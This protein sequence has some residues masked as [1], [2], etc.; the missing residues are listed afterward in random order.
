MIA[1]CYVR[2]KTSDRIEFDYIIPEGLK[3][4][5][6]DLVEVPFLNKKVPAVV[7]DIKPNSKF[8]KK[9]IIRPLSSNPIL[10]PEQ[11][12][13][14]Q[15]IAYEFL[16][17]PSQAL[18]SFLPNLNKKDLLRIHSP[19]KLK[20]PRS[21]K[22]F[23]IESN[24]SNRLQ[25]FVQKLDPTHQTLIIFSELEQIK[26]ALKTIKSLNP[27]F[28][29]L[30]WHSALTSEQK[31]KTWNKV[32]SGENCIILSS[33]H[34][35]FLPFRDLADI[36]LDKPCAFGYFEDQE[37]RYNAFKAAVIVSK[38]YRSNLYLADSSPN[39]EIYALIK[40][41]RVNL[42]SIKSSINITKLPSL[43]AI[44][45]STDFTKAFKSSRKVLVSGYFKDITRLLCEDCEKE[46]NCSNCRDVYFTQSSLRCNTCSA[47]GPLT[48]PSC[49]STKIKQSFFAVNNIIKIL[50]KHL[51]TE[52]SQDEKSPAKV[53]VKPLNELDGL[54]PVFDLA[55]FPFFDFIATLPYLNSQTNLIRLIRELPSLGVSNLYISTSKPSELADLLAQKKFDEIMTRDLKNRSRNSLP[56]FTR[57][58]ESKNPKLPP[59]LSKLLPDLI[60][61]ESKSFAFLTHEQAKNLQGYVAKHRA[62]L[63]YRLDSPDYC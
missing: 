16:S 3:I 23:F 54:P 5:L 48:C 28:D 57:Y 26:K 11:Y 45:S 52:V 34:G 35:L 60:S 42:I 53:I 4:D 9:Q 18:F 58:F 20:R 15:Q 27:S 61:D 6:F 32:I 7:V 59:E 17:D 63:K 41:G 22:S 44:F 8:A 12:E 39:P 36:Y 56:P 13:L 30:L 38:Q 25:Y 24:H 55:I 51:A 21:R 31:A 1:T 62:N 19:Q 50:E 33:R 40:S 43:Q 46:L 29:V 2:Q 10:T 49:G 47:T 37:P 14:A